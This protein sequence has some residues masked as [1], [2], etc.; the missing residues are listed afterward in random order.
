MDGQAVLKGLP[1]SAGIA[2]GQARLLDPLTPEIPKRRIKKGEV[3]GELARFQLAV[4]ESTKQLKDVQSKL[5][6]EGGGKDH[7]VI[8]GTHLAVLDDEILI[9][10]I[11]DL[12]RSE[13][14]NAEWA[15]KK[16][17][18]K[19]S[20]LFDRIED[21]YLKERKSDLEQISR[22]LI[23]VMLGIET[24]PN[25]EVDGD[26]KVIVV[27]HDLSP[28]DLAQLDR[29]KVAGIAT[30][31][32]G[33]TSHFTILARALGIPSVVG[34]EGATQKI[35]QGEFLILDGFLGRLIV[36]PDTMT[37]KRCEWRKSRYEAHQ[38]EL[39]ALRD[40]PAVTKDGREIRLSANIEFPEEM[41]SMVDHGLSTIG[42]F[43][44]EFLVL[45]YGRIPTEKEHFKLYSDILSFTNP[46]HATIRTFDV[47]GDKFAGAFGLQPE[48]NPALGLRAI[49]LCL[50]SREVFKTQ[51][52][53]MLRASVHG[54]LRI[55]FPMISTL[56][57]VI[58]AKALIEE[59]K[60]ELDRSGVPYSDGV[61]VGIMVEVPSAVAI[62]DMLAEH[63]DFM[64]IGTND[65][66]QYALAIDRSNEHVSYLFR[67]LDPAILR[68]IKSVVDAGREANVEVDM[69][70]EM[71]G[72]PLYT[73]LLIGLELDELSMAVT[74]VLRVKRIIR[75]STAEEA[76]QLAEHALTLPRA[77]DIEKFIVHEM[78]K[79]F[80]EEL[81]ELA[82][83]TES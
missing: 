73:L 47:G 82:F 53:A 55:M 41:P 9:E 61:K 20:N 57:E 75:E 62:A 30:D 3:H 22:R 13:L 66:I 65:L 45:M 2:W 54:N 76:R 49:R 42:L 33:K 43:R 81:E 16:V 12:I 23:Q 78:R 67:P 69:C 48:T 17:F 80:P 71:A 10:E 32:G 24:K 28:A 31:I 68:M 72:D 5:G 26:D 4:E 6:A 56:D 74:N 52:R 77:G 46:N 37:L 39:L 70:G 40:Y 64:S 58:E 44:S 36:R 25:L 1:G 7:A 38:K 29:N 15:V 83:Q 21:D 59:V 27:A 8:I 60:M 79:R 35:K 18:D 11:E 50:R 19:H 51:I 63:V 14:I 34:V